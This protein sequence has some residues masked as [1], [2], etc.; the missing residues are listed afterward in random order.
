[1]KASAPDTS[2]S[3]LWSLLGGDAS[4]LDAL[5]IEGPSNVLPSTFDVTTFAASAVGVATL[6]AAELLRV[7]TSTSLR[8]VAIDT[9]SWTR[10]AGAGRGAVGAAST[11]SCR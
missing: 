10:M 8:R 2:S 5:T 4:S 6:A 3:V 7:R 1:M 11:A 9:L